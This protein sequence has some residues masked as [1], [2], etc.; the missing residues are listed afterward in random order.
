MTSHILQ[1]QKEHPRRGRELPRIFGKN[2][3]ELVFFLI[4]LNHL[5]EN[6]S[7]YE[8][9]KYMNL[10][11]FKKDLT[12]MQYKE[13]TLFIKEKINE[14]KR[15]FDTN[16]RSLS[17]LKVKS[18]LY[19]SKIFDLLIRHNDTIFKELLKH[20]D[21][22]P[23]NKAMRKYTTLLK[24]MMVANYITR[25]LVLTEHRLLVPKVLAI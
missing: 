8:I 7:I 5:N 1:S 24:T 21:Y 13:I 16:N 3:H 19:K 2:Y 10:L 18:P 23:S 15:K 14:T 20:T 17:A 6:L 22:L 11:W 9:F 12:F 4:W 25:R